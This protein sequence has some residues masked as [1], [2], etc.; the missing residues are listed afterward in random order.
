[1]TNRAASRALGV[2]RDDAKVCDP[3]CGAGLLL[4]AAGV[5]PPQPRPALLESW[6]R[7]VGAAPF[8]RVLFADLVMDA[9]VGI[10]NALLALGSADM[11]DA[12]VSA[13]LLGARRRSNSTRA[14][15]PGFASVRRP[16]TRTG[17]TPSTP[18]R[19]SPV[20]LGA[21]LGGP[22]D[23]PVG[24]GVAEIRRV[25]IA[26]PRCERWRGS[27]DSAERGRVGAGPEGLDHPGARADP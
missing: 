19:C 5:A 9:R 23:P 7:N 6:E 2:T 3:F 21:A 27:T 4:G 8:A 22:G 12:V 15:S 18:C 20:D 11:F 10:A 26:S 14:R 1:M 16:A 24:A 17:F 25:P 13:P